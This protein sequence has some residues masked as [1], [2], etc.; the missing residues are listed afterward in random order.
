MNFKSRLILLESCKI[1]LLV[2]IN[3]ILKIPITLK[4]PIGIIPIPIL[5]IMCTIIFLWENQFRIYLEMLGIHF[6]C[7]RHNN[8]IRNLSSDTHW[9]W[10]GSFSSV[11]WV[12]QPYI[13]WGKRSENEKLEGAKICFV[14]LDKSFYLLR[15]LVFSFINWECWSRWSLR[16]LLVTNKI[17]RRF[18]AKCNPF[19][20]EFIFPF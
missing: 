7:A 18:E 10:R 3:T 15:S 19:F 5:K 2:N 16:F 14:T 20:W 13:I 11:Q 8:V 9:T 6:S 17:Q 4:I 1:V 12:V